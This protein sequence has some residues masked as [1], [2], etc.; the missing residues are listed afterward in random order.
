MRVVTYGF[1]CLRAQIDNQLWL[2]GQVR[3]K[4]SKREWQIYEIR[5]HLWNIA[6][7]HKKIC[8]FKNGLKP[9]LSG[10]MK[11]FIIVVIIIAYPVLKRTKCY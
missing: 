10:W 8:I 6:L 5:K 9:L 11:L 7:N 3:Q 4:T 2:I 1:C